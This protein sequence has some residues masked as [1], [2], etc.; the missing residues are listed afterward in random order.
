MLYESLIGNTFFYWARNFFPEFYLEIADWAGEWGKWGARR[1]NFHVIEISW[2]WIFCP[3]DLGSSDFDGVN[4][5]STLAALTHFYLGPISYCGYI[6]VKPLTEDRLLPQSSW[7]KDCLAPM[8]PNGRDALSKPA[9]SLS[10]HHVENI[11]KTS[12]VE[13][14]REN[15]ERNPPLLPQSWDYAQ[16]LS[17]HQRACIGLLKRSWPLGFGFRAGRRSSFRERVFSLA[18]SN[19]SHCPRKRPSEDKE[20]TDAVAETRHPLKLLEKRPQSHLADFQKM[21]FM[22]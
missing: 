7:D 6:Q 3:V 11:S 16:K 21:I 15:L 22:T 19:K 20:D 1:K 10:S 12:V 9:Q 4:V 8:N 2:P 13:V 5:I 18:V 14:L 17:F